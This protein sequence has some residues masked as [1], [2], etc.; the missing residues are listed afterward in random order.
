VPITHQLFLTT[1]AQGRLRKV[2]ESD[3]ALNCKAAMCILTTS[4]QKEEQTQ[5]GQLQAWTHSMGWESTVGQIK[6]KQHNGCLE[7]QS[8]CL[9]T[10]NK[11]I[12][13]RLPEQFDQWND[14]CHYPEQILDLGDR[15]FRDCFTYFAAIK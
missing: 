4:D 15:N 2:I 1:S 11:G 6:N 10:A 8:M 7:G 13:D 14:G 9:I 12:I 5:A 3:E